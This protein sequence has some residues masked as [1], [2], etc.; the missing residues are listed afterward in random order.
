VAESIT[1]DAP[2]PAIAQANPRIQVDTHPV[3][4]YLRNIPKPLGIQEIRYTVEKAG[5][6]AA[7]LSITPHHTSQYFKVCENLI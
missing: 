2:C 3:T 6:S 7:D 4:L 1:S 5:I